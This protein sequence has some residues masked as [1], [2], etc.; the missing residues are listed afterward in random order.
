[1]K[2][3]V[4]DHTLKIYKSGRQLKPFSYPLEDTFPQLKLFVDQNFLYNTF[5]FI[6]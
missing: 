3:F 4:Y 2:Y 6:Q 5:I 1:M